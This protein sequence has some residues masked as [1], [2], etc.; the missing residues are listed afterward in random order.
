[1]GSENTIRTGTTKSNRSFGAGSSTLSSILPISSK[2]FGIVRAVNPETREIKYTPI[3]NNI[4]SNKT[5]SAFPITTNIVHLPK[6]GYVVRLEVGPN[7][8]I[9]VPGAPG[10][11][12]IYYDPNPIGIWNSVNDN[13]IEVSNSLSPKTSD[14]TIN[15]DN[16]NKS[17]IGI[18]NG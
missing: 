2:N 11:N 15:K 5:A 16:I 12:T 17:Q 14:V 8:D 13:Q 18:P 10:A 1:M 3:V 4:A 7:I 6:P 9:T